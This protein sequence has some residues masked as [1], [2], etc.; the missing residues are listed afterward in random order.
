L[1][2]TLIQLTH[3]FAIPKPSKWSQI[4]DSDQTG[5]QIERPFY[6]ALDRRS[7]SNY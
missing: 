6:D 7:G 2:M 4:I 1:L 5:A 3:L